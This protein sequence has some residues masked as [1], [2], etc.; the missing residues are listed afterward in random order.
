[1]SAVKDSVGREKKDLR[2]R[3]KKKSMRITETE[4]GGGR[5]AKCF[6]FFFYVNQPGFACKGG[7]A[8]AEWL[9]LIHIPFIHRQAAQTCTHTHM[10]SYDTDVLCVTKKPLSSY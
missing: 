3:R 6:S 4:A 1:M 2:E 9:E 8:W 5:R 7:L 10:F